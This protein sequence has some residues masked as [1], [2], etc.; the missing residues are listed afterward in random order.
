MLLRQRELRY[1][2]V[3]TSFGSMSAAGTDRQFAAVQRFR[4][5]C[6]GRAEQEWTEFKRRS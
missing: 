1:A 5:Q 3:L 2:A 4:Q 6:E